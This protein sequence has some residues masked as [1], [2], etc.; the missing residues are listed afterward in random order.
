MYTTLFPSFI[1]LVHSGSLMG[2]KLAQSSAVF[3]HKYAPFL[4]NAPSRL[5]SLFCELR[6]SRTDAV[7]RSLVPYGHNIRGQVCI[8]SH[9]YAS[10]IV[11]KR[12]IA[13]KC[14]V[15][16]TRHNKCKYVARLVGAGKR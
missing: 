2:C 10:G 12:G 14:T 9:M 11:R 5:R 16:H 6:G 13:H 7:C 15:V 8:Q 4:P 1:R 3:A